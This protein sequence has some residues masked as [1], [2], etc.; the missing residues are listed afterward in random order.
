MYTHRYS[1]LPGSSKLEVS[2]IFPEKGSLAKILPEYLSK[3]TTDKIREQGVNII[4][5]LEL[6]SA[7]LANNDKQVEL[8]LSDGKKVS[9]DLLRSSRIKDRTI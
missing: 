3:W 1:F 6:K 9:F 8:T 7:V 2:Q 5:G 4:S